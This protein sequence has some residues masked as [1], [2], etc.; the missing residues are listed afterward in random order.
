MPSVSSR[1]LSLLAGAYASGRVSLRPGQ[2]VRAGRLIAHV[3][4]SGRTTGPH[5]HWGIRYRGSWLDPG[6]I[7]RAMVRGRRLQPSLPQQ[8]SQGRK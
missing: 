4:L 3:G 8:F 2:M 5:L 6:L 1:R 7:L